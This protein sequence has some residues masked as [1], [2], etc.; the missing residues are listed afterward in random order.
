L[1]RVEQFQ[2]EFESL[3]SQDRALFLFANWKQMGWRNRLMVAGVKI[4]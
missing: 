1:D 4:A 3:S 2:K